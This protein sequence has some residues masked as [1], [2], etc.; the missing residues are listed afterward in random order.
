MKSSAHV[1]RMT[2]INTFKHPLARTL[3]LWI[4]K[5]QIIN[6]N[7]CVRCVHIHLSICRMWHVQMCPCVHAQAHSPQCNRNGD[8][9]GDA[10][11]AFLPQIRCRFQTETT[12]TTTTTTASTTEGLLLYR[13]A[14]ERSSWSSHFHDKWCAWTTAQP[15]NLQKPRR[16]RRLWSS[17]RLRKRRAWQQ[18]VVH[19][20]S[21]GR[22]GIGFHNVRESAR[23]RVSNRAAHHR[24]WAFM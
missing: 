12:T 20:V 18:Y 23:V 5:F 3:N 10:T 22:W 24:F 11:A 6:R 8:T 14:A 13:A 2:S 21:T 16:R 4:S 9:N 17:S 1:C 15:F 19:G 7:C